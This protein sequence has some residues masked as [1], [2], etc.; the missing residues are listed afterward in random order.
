MG[1]AYLALG[2]SGKAKMALN[3]GKLVLEEMERTS[4]DSARR[5]EVYATWL[6]S[7]SLYLTSVGQKTQSAYAYNQAKHHF[8]LHQ[9]HPSLATGHMKLSIGATL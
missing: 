6:L 5:S 3:R 4:M 9:N 8:D 7:H 2:Y 1:Q